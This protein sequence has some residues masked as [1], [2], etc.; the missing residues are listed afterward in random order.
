MSKIEKLIERLKS[1]PKDFTW[2]EMLKVLNYFGYEEL[3]KGKT[4]GSRRK[5]VNQNKQIISL[6]EPHPQRILKAY[7]LD[8]I[9]DFLNL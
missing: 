8:I 1:K 9:I 6:H 2:E 5:F 7:Q 3:S 4:G